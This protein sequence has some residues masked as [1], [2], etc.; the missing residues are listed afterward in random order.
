MC[1]IVDDMKY[2]NE[3]C[4]NSYGVAPTLYTYSWNQR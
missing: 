1:D 4:N 2:T 3:F